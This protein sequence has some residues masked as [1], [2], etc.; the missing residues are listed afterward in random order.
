MKVLLLQIDG[1]IPNLAL[2]RISDHH[3]NLGDEVELRHTGN[4]TAVELHLGDDYDAVY[5]SLIFQHSQPVARRLLEIYPSAASP[6]K[7]PRRLPQSTTAMT[8]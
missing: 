6:M 7:Q 3:R 5:A 8:P 2:M 1:K 4:V